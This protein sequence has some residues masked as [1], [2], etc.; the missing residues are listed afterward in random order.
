MKTSPVPDCRQ[1]PPV[2]AAGSLQLAAS[3]MKTTS[4][5]L[6]GEVLQVAVP[7]ASPQ[8]GPP[9]TSSRSITVV[10]VINEGTSGL[11]AC[12]SAAL[13]SLQEACESQGARLE[14]LQFGK[15]DFGETT[16]LDRFY[17]A[18]EIR[19]RKSQHA[20]SLANAIQWTIPLR[21]SL[22]FFFTTWINNKLDITRHG[23]TNGVVQKYNLSRKK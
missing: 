21:Q 23:K 18:V 9:A 6:A 1:Q 10:Y 4:M 12:E 20:A 5:P 17:N 14:T 2:R 11:Q 19:L 3:G 7:K 13:H 16:V 8:P 22:E 15:L